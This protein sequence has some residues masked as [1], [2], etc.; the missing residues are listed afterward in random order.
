MLLGIFVT[1]STR[2]RTMPAATCQEELADGGEECTTVFRG[3]SYMR[4]EEGRAR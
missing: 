3:E 2:R 1:K 4:A